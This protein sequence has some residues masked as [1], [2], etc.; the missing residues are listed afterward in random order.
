MS[1]KNMAY[2][3]GLTVLLSVVV[4]LGL[5]L[6]Q[7]LADTKKW[8]DDLEGYAPVN[9]LF[10]IP[11]ITPASTT[12]AQASPDIFYAFCRF[13]LSDQPVKI[14]ASLP[15]SYWSISMY[16]EKSDN[17]YVINNR[18]AGQSELRLLLARV[19]ADGESEGEILDVPEN[20]ILVSSP[21]VSGL[22]VFRA[23]VPDKSSAE[24][25]RSIY[26]KTRCEAL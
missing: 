15:D 5:V 6:L 3:G 13:D 20:T 18:Q 12:F 19:D 9:Q 7:P 2:W 8:F 25:V 17:F 26:Q 21:S 16:S 1:I 24:T 14:A 11:E 4:H 10:Q 22:I 23:A